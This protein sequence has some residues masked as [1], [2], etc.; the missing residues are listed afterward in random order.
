MVARSQRPSESWWGAYWWRLLGEAY[1]HGVGGGQGE[2]ADPGRGAGFLEGGDEG[3]VCR[4]TAQGGAVDRLG[5]DDR[6]VGG[7]RQCLEGR[8]LQQPEDVVDRASGH[9]VLVA[10][11]LAAVQGDPQ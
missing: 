1:R 4:V 11:D 7:G 9:A 10:V 8:G 2:E 3:C 5:G 6:Q